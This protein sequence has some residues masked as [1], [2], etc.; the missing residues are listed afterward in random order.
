MNGIGAFKLK[1][2]TQK[3]TMKYNKSVPFDSCSFTFLSPLK[4]PIAL[5]EE[6]SEI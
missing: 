4:S 1:K 3:N 2:R 5:C 6:Q